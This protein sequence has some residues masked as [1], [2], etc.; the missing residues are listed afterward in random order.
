MRTKEHEIDTQ[1]RKKVLQSFPKNWE[2]REF[3]GRDYGIDLFVEIFDTNIP[4]GNMIAIQLK[5]TEKDF[6][7]KLTIDF[8]V[9]TLKYSELFQ[10]PVIL[11]ICPIN[12]INNRVYY[13]WLQEYINVILNF[14]KPD[15]R[16][17]KKTIRLNIPPENIVS[18]NIEKIEFIAEQL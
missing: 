4:K 8:P 3:T 12:D 6:A 7:K 17:N 18:N 13:L 5:G 9:N 16:E 10:S 15:W 14:E 1:A 2:H 11:M